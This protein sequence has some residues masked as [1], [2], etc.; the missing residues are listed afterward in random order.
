MQSYRVSFA[1]LLMLACLTGLCLLSAQPAHAERT[2]QVDIF[3]PGQNRINHYLAPPLAAEG[4][5]PPPFAQLLGATIE[6]NLAFLPYLVTTRPGDILGGPQVAGAT[7]QRLD[8]KRFQLSRVDVVLTSLWALGV[9]GE[10]R[11]ELR[12]YDSFS[13]ELLV[14]RAYTNVK[15][16]DLQEV[17]RLFCSELAK[18]LT[19]TDG[20]FDTRLAFVKATGNTKEIWTM[21][22]TGTGKRQL[23]DLG[24]VSLS[25]AWSFDGRQLAFTYLGREGHRL[26]VWQQGEAKPRLIELKGHSVISPA[27]T[28]RG[29]IAVTLDFTGQPDIWLLTDS[30]RPAEAIVEGW[31]IDVSP[32]FDRDGTRMTFNSGRLGNPHV[33]VKDLRTNEVRRVT[34]DGKY[35]THPR[36]SPDGRLVAF[37]RTV[38]G[39]HRIFVHDLETGAERQVSFGP[40]D[41][42]EPTWSPGGYFIVFTSSRSGPYGLYMTTRHGHEAIPLPAVEAGSEAINPAW[43]VRSQ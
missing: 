8:F 39:R 2:L 37:S 9:G 5:T 29:R 30:Y 33:F 18:A 16:D 15:A 27:F 12:A 28:P 31:A 25:P 14:G 20:F 43:T 32:S 34:F 22:P 24:Q 42:E 4:Q 38:D 19:G 1:R 3:G 11:V 26:G 21:H 13:A 41:D 36:I 35:N 40:G 17:A 23:T 10:P 6:S 7:G